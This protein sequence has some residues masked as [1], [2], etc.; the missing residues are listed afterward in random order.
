[1]C[2][3]SFLLD[4]TGQLGPEAA[5]R[6]RA[7]TAHRG[8][9]G[10]GAHQFGDGGP[11]T[12]YLGH[13]RLKIV[14]LSD[15]ANQPM[16]AADGRYALVFNGEIYNWR[17]LRAELEFK[18]VQFRTQSDTEVL[19]RLLIREGAAA[20]HR[21]RGMFA[22]VFYDSH[23]RVVL[24][25]RDA[26]GIK[27]L[28]SVETKEGFAISSEPAG[29]L[30]S[31]LVT[32]AFNLWQLKPYL[33]MRFA[34]GDSPFW[35]H[36]VEFEPSLV[37]RYDSGNRVATTNILA[38]V[39]A[40]PKSVADALDATIT[41]GSLS[42]IRQGRQFRQA[43]QSL[44]G[45]SI[46]RHLAADVPVGLWL[47]GGVD[48]TLLLA[49]ARE[50]GHEVPCFSVA[51]RAEEG[52][53]GSDD[54]RF[55]REAAK[56]YEA[57]YHEFEASDELLLD[58]DEAL[59]SLSQPIA[60]SS[61]LLTWWLAKQTSREVKA[62]LSGAGADEWFAGY[63]RHQAFAW[64]LRNRGL[65]LVAKPVLAAVGD[66]LSSATERPWR[67][68]L[69]LMQK[70]VARIDRDPFRTLMNFVRL[71]PFL[72]DTLQEEAQDTS[73]FE[74]LDRLWQPTAPLES[75]LEYDRHHYLVGDILALTDQTAMRH[76]L[77]VRTPY[78]DQDLTAYVGRI[79]AKELLRHGP[80]WMLRELL[81]QRG[82]QAFTKRSKEGF[83]LPLTRWLRMPKYSWLFDP[84][85]RRDHPLFEHFDYARTQQFLT[86][87]QTGRHDLGAEAWALIMLFR[88]YDL[89]KF[90]APKP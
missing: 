52:S 28:F 19:L 4:R 34:E 57:E 9:D 46:T 43:V 86:R 29:V 1:M 73:D 22:F 11:G 72:T 7:A 10:C 20:L 27:P 47:S 2:G 76:G 15:E 24:A 23:E 82:G 17:E 75:L 79:P 89:Q 48:S 90:S 33:S 58:T 14:D 60:D 81:D 41:L 3:I 6:M 71:D 49:L 26:E 55:A 61:V 45:Q 54:R 80:K 50:M 63:N 18:A 56:Q 39:R 78:L 59:A 77:E 25:G 32:G 53:F 66:R 85:R 65:L 67:K 64:Y 83:G 13:N 84:I 12:V 16:L 5:A 37:R 35:K 8:P 21:L 74:L 44:L 87:F 30:A 31:G 70:L 38:Q 88:W 42:P 36:V 68:R 69:R 62:V 51:L 40:V